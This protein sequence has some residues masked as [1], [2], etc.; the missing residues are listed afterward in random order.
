MRVAANAFVERLAVSTVALAAVVFVETLR[1]LGAQHAGASIAA[2]SIAAC[3]ALPMFVAAA[4]LAHIAPKIGRVRTLAGIVLASSAATFV[5][6]FS[7]LRAGRFAERASVGALVV[8]LAAM[9]IGW[10][11]SV[12]WLRLRAR[13]PRAIA[14][15][16]LS[17]AIGLAELNQRWQPRLYPTLHVALSIAM[18]ACVAVAG[19]AWVT[20]PRGR[21]AVL[22]LALALGVSAPFSLVVLGGDALSR[23]LVHENSELLRPVVRVLPALSADAPRVAVEDPL[24]RPIAGPTLTTGPRDVLLI[25][26][27]ALRADHVGVY[28]HR[29]GI[30]PNLD[31]LAA[32]G[33]WFEHAYTSAPQTS[34][35]L[36]SIMLGKH[37]RPSLDLDAAGVPR[38]RDVTWAETLTAHGYRTAAFYPE[39][40]FFTDRPRFAELEARRFGFELAVVDYQSAEARCA[41]TRAFVGAMPPGQRFFA[42]AH[43]FEPHE[44]YDGHPDFALGDGE[45][46]RYDA[47]IAYVDR[48]IGRLVQDV[49]AARPD[50]IVIVTAD[51]GEAFGEHGSRFHGTTMFEEQVRVPL[52]VSIP[53]VAPRVVAAPVQTVDVFPTTARAL[54]VPLLARVRGRDLGPL[55][56][57]ARDEGVAFASLP[58]VTL[59]A[60]GRDRLICTRATNACVR[61]DLALDPKQTSP[62]VGDAAALLAMHDAIVGGHRAMETAPCISC[63]EPS[64]PSNVFP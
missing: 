2:T 61:Y 24:A 23:T 11:A 16:A 45:L 7:V 1:S 18:V 62:R 13:A 60:T 35:A 47:E 49:R 52:I 32:E 9:V 4:A 40:V 6:A 50:I 20:R 56:R 19:D 38:P 54:S 34:Y 53:G 46:D 30:T 17:L 48:E 42:W 26:V 37:F 3:A 59:L 25:T 36:S 64:P 5:A 43:L 14:P 41:A 28:G 33:V 29:R 55:L 12:I 22:G 15:I 57:G 27:D 8:A 63:G 51:H 31:A 21:G 10:L 58:E 44:P 39:T